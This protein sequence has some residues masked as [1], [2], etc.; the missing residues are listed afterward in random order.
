MKMIRADKK[1]IAI[2]V[3]RETLDTL[4][5]NAESMGITK[6][7]LIIRYIAMIGRAGEKREMLFFKHFNMHKEI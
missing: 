4:N 7:E 3:D 6:S 2:A 5:Y 1:R